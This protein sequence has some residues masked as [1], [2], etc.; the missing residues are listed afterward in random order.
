M[1]GVRVTALPLALSPVPAAAA[2]PRMIAPPPAVDCS[3]FTAVPTGV[4]VEKVILPVCWL[5]PK[6]SESAPVS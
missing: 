1:P 6:V 2:S 4:A 5:S 3:T